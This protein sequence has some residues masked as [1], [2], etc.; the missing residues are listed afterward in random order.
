[1][2]CWYP[3]TSTVA[4]E[5][6]EGCVARHIC[7]IKKPNHEGSFSFAIHL[8]HIFGFCEDYDKVLNG[9]RH[10]LTLV[11]KS[12]NNAIFKAAAVAN[13]GK[14][15]LSKVSWM[16]PRVQPNDEIKYKLYKSI[17]SKSIL[18]AAF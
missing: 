4:E 10:T 18:D 12:D 3:D 5:N 17:E 1:M 14:V 7:I 9:L 8:E 15:K 13:A 6:N 11:K 2:Q 16:M